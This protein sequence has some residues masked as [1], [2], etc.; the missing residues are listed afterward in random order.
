MSRTV[1]LVLGS[2]GARGMAHVGVIRYLE[3]REFK[4]K[5][6]SGCSMGAVI[7]GVYALG[8]LPEFEAW[9]SSM[10]PRDIINLLDFTLSD[11]GLVKGERIMGV[12]DEMI[13]DALIED[14]PIPYTAVATDIDEEKE[15]WINSGPLITAMRA[16]AAIPVLFTPA[17]FG[18]RKLIDGGVLNPVPIAPTF[19]DDTDL[20]IAVNLSGEAV[21]QPERDQ[22]PSPQQQEQLHRRALSAIQ[23]FKHNAIKSIVSDWAMYE[24]ANK[25][26]D[27]MQGAIARQK[28][29]AYP[30][31]ALVEIPRNACGLLEFNRAE[32]IIALGYSSAQE[33]LKS[34][35]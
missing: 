23:N 2:G 25:A 28:L 7:G 29:A 27:T 18:H 35:A 6:I 3:E 21:A 30:P 12:L 5:A 22:A 32:E 11:G 19:G 24:V 31:D 9:L 1:S 17:T 15:V 8:K 16:T 14:L 26:F 20:T 13:G 34:L 4:I 10:E 33:Q